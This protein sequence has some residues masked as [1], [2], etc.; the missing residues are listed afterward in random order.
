LTLDLCSKACFLFQTCSSPDGPSSPAFHAHASWFSA[1]GSF[2]CLLS[3]LVSHRVPPLQRI[4]RVT[5]QEPY[6]E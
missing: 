5:I 4:W 6:F 2:L 1:S 3:A